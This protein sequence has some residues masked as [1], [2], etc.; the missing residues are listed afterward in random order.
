MLVGC[1]NTIEIKDNMLVIAHRGG[2]LVGNE[3]TLSAFDNAICMGVDMVEIDVHQS[4]DTQLIVCHDETLDRTTDMKGRIEEL[5]LPE[6]R[7]A[8]ILDRETEEPTEE[9]VPTLEETLTLM[10]GRCKVLLEIKRSREDQY[11]GIEERVLQMVRDCDMWD[12]TVIQSFDDRVLETVHQLAPDMRVEKLIFCTLPF[13]YCFDNRITK[14]SVEKY[15]YCASINVC[16]A[17]TSNRFVK[18]MHQHGF[19]V[20]CW[21]VNEVDDL[22]DNVDGVISN[23]PDIFMS[24]RSKH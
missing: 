24:S 11:P 3:N 20:K 19:E 4:K 14:F 2:A 16:A 1:S 8:H 21:T 9:G 5:T 22:L 23:R 12:S 7:K 13:G 10:K 18:R 6:I 17:V 15:R